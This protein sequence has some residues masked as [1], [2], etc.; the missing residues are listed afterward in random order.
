MPAR[1]DVSLAEQVDRYAEA[2]STRW[3]STWAPPTTGPGHRTGHPTLA[4]DHDTERASAVL[5][6]HLFNHSR[7]TRTTELSGPDDVLGFVR[8]LYGDALSATR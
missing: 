7:A 5:T 4:E 1:A 6:P 3:R 2:V 8:P